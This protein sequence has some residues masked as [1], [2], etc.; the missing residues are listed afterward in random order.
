MS[1]NRPGLSPEMLLF[2]IAALCSRHGL[3]VSSANPSASRHYAEQLLRSL[4][5]TT[6]QPPAITAHPAPVINEPT[7]E[8]PTIDNRTHRPPLGFPI[9]SF[10]SRSLGNPLRVVRDEA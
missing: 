7:T 6:V 4:A 8:L 5:I 10:A 2:E 3:A 9:G 1:H